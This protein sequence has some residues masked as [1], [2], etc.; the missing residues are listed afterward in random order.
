MYN[1]S[2]NEL[3]R[4]Q[5]LV[6]SAIVQVDAAPFKAWYAAHYGTEVGLKK[7]AGGAAAA[8]EKKE[9]EK[10]SNHATRKLKARTSGGKGKL[11]S[12]L[13]DQFATG[14]LY[15]AIASRPGQC[16]RADG[17]ILEGKEL[18]FYVRKMAKKKGKA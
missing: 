17:Y 8:E 5:T 12:A 18:E 1:A 11:D 4:T 7:R 16:G 13:D 9:P 15:A 3:V 14:R 6:K 10:K 2:N